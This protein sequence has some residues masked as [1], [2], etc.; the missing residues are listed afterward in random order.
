M[1]HFST[2]KTKLKNKDLLVKAL[3]ALNY[4]ALENVLLENPSD[5]IHEQVEVEVG[6]T[7]YVGFKR[8]QDGT[9]ELVAERDAWD[10]QITIERFLQ[11]VTQSYARETVMQTVQEKGYS[12]VS[13]QKSVDNTIELVVE[14]W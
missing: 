8:S 2:I 11:K 4:A 5:H 7:R 1:S 13:E 12:V 6:V 9:L 3:N 10:E 14:K